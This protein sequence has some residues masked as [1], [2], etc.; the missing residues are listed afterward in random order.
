MPMQIFVRTLTGKT[1]TLDVESSDLVEDVKQKIED[2][3]GIP[4]D[5]QRL[6]FA[7]KIL[8]DGHTLCSLNVTPT[9]TLQLVLRLRGG[10]MFI[11]N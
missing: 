7:G 1:I 5:E 8:A 10:I 11:F 2:R 6:V 3:E 4:L 9:S